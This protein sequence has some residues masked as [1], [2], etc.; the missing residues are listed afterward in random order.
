MGLWAYWLVVEPTAVVSMGINLSGWKRNT[1]CATTKSL[2][3]RRT[4]LESNQ[5]G[6]LPHL[7]AP[8]TH[9]LDPRVPEG[10][11]WPSKTSRTIAPFG[12]ISPE[13][14]GLFDPGATLSTGQ[15]C[16][17]QRRGFKG[18]AARRAAKGMW[19]THPPWADSSPNRP[20][21]AI[22]SS[23]ASVPSVLWPLG[24]LEAPQWTIHWVHWY[25]LIL[26]K[27]SWIKYVLHWFK[28]YRNGG[29]LK[30]GYPHSWM[31]YKKTS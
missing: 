29:F 31:V 19:R 27:T 13:S 15:P 16:H 26:L 30:W 20:T 1:I 7:R 23:R 9:L 17:P 12:T 18:L 5:M 14:P 11:L 4:I 10:W 2:L 8:S 28:M 25:G 3:F 24:T 21:P 22:R 6:P